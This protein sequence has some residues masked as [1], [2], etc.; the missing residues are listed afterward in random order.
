[1]KKNKAFIIQKQEHDRPAICCY[2]NELN[3]D[4]FAWCVYT[5]NKCDN[6]S[7]ILFEKLHELQFLNYEIKF[8]IK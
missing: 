4:N 1:M 8:I 6:T 7:N 3:E 5:D 2:L